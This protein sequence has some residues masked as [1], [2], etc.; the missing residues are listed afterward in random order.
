MN[1]LITGADGF[2]G[3]KITKYILDKTSFGVIGT[4]LS[5][6]RVGAMLERE[7]IQNDDRILFLKVSFKIIHML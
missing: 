4:T 3:G 2:L 1:I 7:G 6:D 5:M